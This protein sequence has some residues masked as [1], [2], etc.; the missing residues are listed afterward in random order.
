MT[1]ADPTPAPSDA[2]PPYRDPSRSVDERLDDLLAR[3][4]LDEKLAQLG[5]FW[6][7]EVLT[8]LALDEAKLLELAADGIGHVT[9]I[10]GSTNLGPRDGALLA[11]AIQRHLVERTRL[12]IPAMVHEESLH[13]VMGAD[14]TCYPQSIG[15]AATWDPELVER[16]AARIGRE[17][18]AGGAHQT[19]A[20][21]IDISRDPRWGRFE[22]TYGE[23]P[24]LAARMGVAY[25]RGIQGPDDGRGPDGVLATGK[26]MVGHGIPE[27]GLNH[28]PAH[29]G[30]RE[31]RDR[32]LLPFEAAVKAGHIRSMMHAYDDLDGVPCVASKE[33][34]T[35]ILRE[36]WGFDGPVVSD[37]M[38]IELLERSHRMVPDQ[39]AAARLALEAGVDSDLPTTVAYG[40]PLRAAI[41]AGEVGMD[42][43]DRSVRRILREKLT[44]G[45][46]EQ[47]YVDP[48]APELAPGA[49]EAD[50]GLALEAARRSLVLLKNDGVLPLEAPRAIAVIGPSADSA[51]NLVGD[52]A[53]VVHLE[54]LLENR[55]RGHFSV[56]TDPGHFSVDGLLDGRATVLDGIR[57]RAGAG[58]VVRFA[59]GCGLMDG[60]D[61]A[62]AAGIAAAADAARGADI[63]IVVVGERS[64]LTDDCQSG[65]ARDR[66]TLGLP[67]RQSE[68]VAAVVA[69]GTPVVLVLVSGRPLA[70]VPEAASCAAVLHAWV[71]GDEGPRAIAE[72]LFG[73][74]SPGGRLPVTVPWSV[75][76]VPIHYAHKPSGGRSNWKGDYVDGPHKPLFPFGFGLGYT[77]FSQGAL[78]VA[79]PAVAAGG[80]VVASLEVTNTGERDGDEVV[81]LYCHDVEASVTR[82]VLQLCGFARVAVRAGATRRVTF[83]VPAD[84][85][86]F[87]GVDGRLTLEP[88]AIELM[89]GRSAAD[90]TSRV[91]VEIEGAPVVLGGRERFWAEVEVN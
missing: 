47:P 14:R 2:A 72:V 50:R 26:H 60:D 69:T 64:G 62:V 32:F 70:I 29:L 3:M 77:T 48:D 40:A 91:T 75:G 5:S 33:L 53:H 56:T 30:D 24:V 42:L 63:A 8:D 89:V 1:L 59:P 66:L 28:A 41:E 73:D 6:A 10:V 11:N 86:A 74:E 84:A 7:F 12:G 81:Q 71:P 49:R 87:T 31:L 23:D 4:T 52:Y 16:V 51:R 58:S 79:R 35:S 54:S 19:L 83:R 57:A 13:G 39:R 36:E 90:I 65:E 22:E 25:V 34:L 17:L 37:Y 85:F 21:V 76:Q 67:G 45:L 44:L 43:V 68:L 38:G 78:G 18:R 27:G 80:E 20:P 55:T 61:P 9:R 88:G 46:F 82:P 15:L